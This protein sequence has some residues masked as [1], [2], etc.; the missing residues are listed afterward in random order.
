MRLTK[1][2]RLWD[3]GVGR[4]EVAV[5][6]VVQRPLVQGMLQPDYVYILSTGSAGIYVWVG[7]NADHEEQV[8]SKAL[9]TQF[10][11]NDRLPPWTPITRM[12]QDN[13]TPSFKQYFGVWP[14]DDYLTE[15]QKPRNYTIHTAIGIMASTVERPLPLYAAKKKLSKFTFAC[16]PGTGSSST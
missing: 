3:E 16:S 9:A 6:E 11:R 14:L 8:Q 15:R 5:E 13:E 1:R 12:V 10:A 7:G 4:G 2:Y